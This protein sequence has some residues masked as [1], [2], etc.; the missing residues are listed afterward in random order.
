MSPIPA[1]RTV[2]SPAALRLAA[3]LLLAAG[4]V[5]GCAQPA[6]VSADTQAAQPGE[7]L[8]TLPA[9]ALEERRFWSQP[10]SW[11]VAR[12][13]EP[14]VVVD[15]QELNP[16][17][18]YEFQERAKERA[19]SSRDYNEWLVDTWAKPEGRAWLRD[20]VDVNWVK[21]AHDIGPM[22][23]VRDLTIPGP[24][25]D[26]PI[27]VYWPGNPDA[28]RPGLLYF[29][30]GGFLFASIEAVEPQAK[31]LAEKGDLVVVSVDY[32]LAPEHP[33]P[34]AQ[35]DALAAWDWVRA[36]AAEL[37]IDAARIGVAGDSAGGN[38]S[39]V[40]SS[41][42]AR[43]GEPSP[44][45]QLLYY[46]F[47]DIRFADYPS[48]EIFAS[49]Y[50]LD[51]DFIRIATDA[52][53]TAEEDKQ[54]RWLNLPDTVNLEALPPTIVATSGFDPIRDQGVFFARQ[55]EDAGAH[56]IHR[57]YESLNHGFLEASE[58][59]DDARQACFETARLIGS[60]L[61]E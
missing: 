10:E 50:G 33:F 3:L 20:A 60:L 61:R 28:V 35:E 46:P 17:L 42:T 32:S 34:A 41:E 47:L 11:F 59:I 54:H 18:Q 23:E 39:A 13:D 43:R 25:G 26:I 9:E 12:L 16:K 30:G 38:L 51:Q 31:I 53:L 44:K 2:C 45:A 19:A 21:L 8:A 29:H 6:A 57:H 15:G 37:G 36:H 40:I 22:A 24:N 14:P 27:R 56:V 1:V 7:F 58:T 4:A 5:A 48:Y 49:G 52:F 55:L